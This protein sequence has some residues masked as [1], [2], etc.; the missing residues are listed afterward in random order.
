VQLQTKW[1]KTTSKAFQP[2]AKETKPTTEGNY[3]L[4][5]QSA[6]VKNKNKKLKKFCEG[7]G[8]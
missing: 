1:W 8:L 5:K 6:V 3:T 7:W 4:Y 2:P